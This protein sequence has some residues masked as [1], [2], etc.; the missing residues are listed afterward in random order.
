MFVDATSNN[1]PPYMRICNCSRRL[2]QQCTCTVW[3]TWAKPYG[4]LVHCLESCFPMRTILLHGSTLLESNQ[5]E[6]GN[7]YWMKSDYR[8]CC[9]SS[10]PTPRILTP[11][12]TPKVAEARVSDTVVW[13]T[14]QDSSAE[15]A[16]QLKGPASS[17]ASAQPFQ[18][19][20]ESPVLLHALCFKLNQTC[21]TDVTDLLMGTSAHALCL[22]LEVRRKCLIC[23]ALMRFDCTWCPLPDSLPVL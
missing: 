16:P 23:K 14:S 10:Y 1:S 22:K 6:P 8:E 15:D 4:H 9:R 13:K 19:L 17:Q 21:I 18:P 11:D 7:S 3:A 20:S 12:C 5:K 2:C